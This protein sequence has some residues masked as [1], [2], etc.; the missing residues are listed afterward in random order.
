MFKV[1]FEAKKRRKSENFPS[2]GSAM[3][4]AFE[5]FT[6]KGRPDDIRIVI[7]D[8]SGQVLVDHADI[9]NACRQVRA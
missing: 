9:T 7:L 6:R 1:V 4:C 5:K 8:D 3:N 2:P